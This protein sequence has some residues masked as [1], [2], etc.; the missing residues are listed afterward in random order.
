MRN[1]QEES[2]VIMCVCRPEEVIDTARDARRYNTSK[3]VCSPSATRE[4]VLVPVDSGKCNKQEKFCDHVCVSTRRKL[5]HRHCKGMLGGTTPPK[6]SAARPRRGRC[7]G[8]CK[9]CGINMKR[10]L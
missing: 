10:V 8:S 5:M 1:K 4:D 6:K 2:S 9:I 3:E 7:P